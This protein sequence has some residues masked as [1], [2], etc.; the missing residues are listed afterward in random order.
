VV[1]FGFI[2]PAIADES[3]GAA[4]RALAR[5]TIFVDWTPGGYSPSLIGNPVCFSDDYLD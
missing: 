2:V 3:A 1:I 4:A 5:R